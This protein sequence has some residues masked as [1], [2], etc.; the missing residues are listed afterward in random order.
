[1]DV[2][3]NMEPVKEIVFTACVSL[4]AIELLYFL[5]PKERITDC[6]YALLYTVVLVSGILSLVKS[7]FALDFQVDTGAY[8]EEVDSYIQDYYLVETEQELKKTIAQALDT[9]HIG[10]K[11]VDLILIIDEEE[12][13]NVDSISVM[14]GYRSDIERAA[15][16]LE[17]LFGG[18]IPIDIQGAS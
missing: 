1:M 15:V 11:S 10:V 14:L 7:D 9:V 3:I 5:T 13:L 17:Q 6:V 12:V 8:R 2:G 18:G 4:I 16:I